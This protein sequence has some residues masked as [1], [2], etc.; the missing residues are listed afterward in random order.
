MSAIFVITY[1]IYGFVFILFGLYAIGNHKKEVSIFPLTGPIVYIG[2]FGIAHGMSEWLTML[3][4]TGLFTEHTLVLFYSGQ[5]LKS[6]SFLMLLLFGLCT[7][8]DKKN[9]RRLLIAL[10]LLFITWLSV[11]SFILFSNGVG[12]LYEH[13]IFFTLSIRY[14]MALPG[15]VISFIALIHQGLRIR[16]FNR[17]WMFVYMSFATTILLYGILDGLFVPHEPFFPANI[18]Y[19]EWFTTQLGIPIQYFKIISGVLIHI[20]LLLIL[21]TFQWEINTHWPSAGI[22]PSTFHQHERINQRL[23]DNI[24]QSLFVTGMTLYDLKNKI[25][26]SEIQKAISEINTK[27]NDS[28]EE[29]RKI[30][31]GELDKPIHSKIFERTLNELCQNIFHDDTPEVTIKNNLDFVALNLD[32]ETTA[33]IYFIVQEALLNASKHAKASAILI[34][35]SQELD[36]LKII[37]KD[38]GEGMNIKEEASKHAYGFHSM[39]VRANQISARLSIKSRTKKRLNR[40]K[41]TEINLFVPLMAPRT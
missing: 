5:I 38:N 22:E 8:G 10:S 15:A 25:D 11:L 34:E 2:V 39:H 35:L 28:I 37:I 41:G 3:H 24:I 33:H 36:F 1:L 6:F 17:Q 23:H 21:K 20:N 27:I 14:G 29:L 16:S 9:P 26:D 18:F 19:R 7:L 30:I 32:N 12:Y 31:K 13:Q 4:W 40:R